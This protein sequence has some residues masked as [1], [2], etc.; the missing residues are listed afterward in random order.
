MYL[1]TLRPM[2]H[3]IAGALQVPSDILRPGTPPREVG[4][5]YLAA[6]L[7]DLSARLNHE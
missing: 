3:E 2:A 4:A 6:F 1:K 7:D 5:A